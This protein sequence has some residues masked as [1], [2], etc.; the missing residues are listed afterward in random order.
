MPIQE[1]KGFRKDIARTLGTIDTKI[2]D[3]KSSGDSS[4]TFNGE[5]DEWKT[6]CRRLGE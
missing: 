5:S 2:G 3:R 1:I 6:T 4:L